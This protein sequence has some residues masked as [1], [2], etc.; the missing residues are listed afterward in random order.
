MHTSELPKHLQP[1]SV[2]SQLNKKR[3][4]YAGLMGGAVVALIPLTVLTGIDTHSVTFGVIGFGVIVVTTIVAFVVLRIMKRR[5]QV[6][7]EIAIESGILTPGRITFTYTKAMRE[8][9]YLFF[10][11]EAF[12][13][14]E[15]KTRLATRIPY[16][17][18]QLVACSFSASELAVILYYN[19]KAEPFFIFGDDIDQRLG[20]VTNNAGYNAPSAAVGGVMPTAAAVR[21]GA[22]NAKLSFDAAK[23]FR[24][25]MVRHGVTNFED[26]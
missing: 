15:K 24:D 19:N 7:T 17:S 20:I 13:K 14:Y 2:M 23:T 5:R 6:D 18:I 21:M 22:Q 1:A 12:V 25:E 16:S 9:G 8:Q 10:E 26:F 3:L 11:D 4:L